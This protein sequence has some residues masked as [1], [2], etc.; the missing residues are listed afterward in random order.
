[1][2]DVTFR[3]DS[4]WVPD[5]VTVGAP[6]NSG[7]PYNIGCNV[8]YGG[9]PYRCRKINNTG[10]APTNATYWDL[11]TLKMNFTP[12]P[13]TYTANGVPI[14][15]QPGM[16]LE[17]GGNEVVSVQGV[18]GN[19]FTANFTKSRNVGDTIVCR[20]NPGPPALR[21]A[22]TTYNPRHDSSVVLHLSVIQ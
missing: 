7:T 5:C 22:K 21:G 17:I 19:S 6:W 13:T 11:V 3:I 8:V 16:M 10:I 15:I 14:G 4:Y 9:L 2:A 1:M 18:A 20:G 12:I